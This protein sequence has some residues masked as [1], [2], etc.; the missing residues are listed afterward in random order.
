LRGNAAR[1][2]SPGYHGQARPPG[3]ET[4]D[5]YRVALQGGEVMVIEWAVQPLDRA[6]IVDLPGYGCPIGADEV[7]LGLECAVPPA[8]NRDRLWPGKI[9]RGQGQGLADHRLDRP[10]AP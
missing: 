9:T 7:D 5:G 10:P 8:T 4:G 3:L 2:A 6:G 1:G